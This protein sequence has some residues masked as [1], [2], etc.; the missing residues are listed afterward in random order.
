[1]AKIYYQRVG[2]EALVYEASTKLSHLLNSPMRAVFDAHEDLIP[3]E[4]AKAIYPDLEESQALVL[5]ENALEELAEAGLIEKRYAHDRKTRRDF[6][7]DVGKLA[8]AIP[9]LTSCF[10]PQPAAAQSIT[11]PTSTFAVFPV[12]SENP[13]VGGASTPV[14]PMTISSTICI[15]SGATTVS[16]VA[17]DNN[18]AITGN[19]NGLEFD[20]DV[21][22]S[23]TSPNANTNAVDYGSF[24]D[25]GP[26]AQVVVTAGD[27]SFDI[28]ALFQ[29]GG[30]GTFEPGDYDLD[31]IQCNSQGRSAVRGFNIVVS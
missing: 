8:A 25:C 22:F 20:E 29:T 19:P 17:T 12:G 27:A 14:I 2:D 13:D 6:L 9:I 1:M 24:Q 11:C 18:A 31:I 15:P 4:L 3:E 28:S 21:T 7:G 30:G 5:V 10:M 26:N 23:V 16:L